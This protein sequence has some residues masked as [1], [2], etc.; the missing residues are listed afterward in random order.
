M[1]RLGHGFSE[2][3]SGALLSAAFDVLPQAAAIIG[4][5]AQPRVLSA[6][7]AFCDL[8]GWPADSLSDRPL[9]DLRLLAEPADLTRLVATLRRGDDVRWTQVSLRRQDESLLVADVNSARL[10]TEDER[11]LSVLT[12]QEQRP[13]AAHNRDVN[14]F[15]QFLE[16]N[17]DAVV[18][19]DRI[20]AIT[21]VNAQA[22]RLFGYDRREL[23]GRPV[24]VLVPRRLR[25]SHERYRAGYFDNPRPRPMG[26]GLILR[27]RRRD[28][29][30]FPAEISLSTVDTS[31]GMLA[32][33]A[34]RDISGRLNAEN[35]IREQ[36]HR[37]EI[38]S[39]LLGVE[40]AERARIATSLHDDTIQVLTASLV[41]LDRLS[42]SARGAPANEAWAETIAGARA[43]L[44]QATERTRRL[45][46]E[47]RPTVL[48]E[49]GIAAAVRALAEGLR[50]ETTILTE[51]EVTEERFNWA[52][53][54]LIYRTIQEA[55]A[56]V[57]K[58]AG[59]SQVMVTVRSVGTHVVGGDR[60]RPR[61]RRPAGHRSRADGVSPGPGR[62]VR[63]GAHGRRPDQHRIQPGAWGEGAFRT[64]CGAGVEPRAAAQDPPQADGK[65]RS[66]HGSQAEHLVIGGDGR[67]DGHEQQ[68]RGWN[69][70]VHGPSVARRLTGNRQLEAVHRHMTGAEPQQSRRWASW[71]S[72]HH[73]NSAAQHRLAPRAYQ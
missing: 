62:H 34:V 44:E 21:I 6:N 41:A 70:Q 49:R 61:V 24:D 66:Q 36:E 38:L 16:F 37:R 46:F 5:P 54:E 65:Q 63:A 17:P 31:R 56:N 47:L 57:R 73:K 22:E 9:A 3:L 25:A 55:I 18:G 45:T 19:V 15:E 33:S 10:P 4:A 35:A 43:V 11:S 64:A 67:G 7:R 2:T 39:A 59:A 32:L 23:I 72:T 69:P 14:A 52:V 30:E 13:G 58:H 53:E 60:R 8:L 50:Q 27:G 28:G 71:T 29:S 42:R 20:G 51:L 48:H 68:G 1:S 12:V 26:G 40:E